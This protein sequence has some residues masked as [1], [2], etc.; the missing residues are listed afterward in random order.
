MANVSSSNGLEKR[1]KLRFPG[2]DEPWME[3]KLDS[4]LSPRVEKQIP[5]EDAPLMAFTAEGGVEPK[6][7]RYDRSYL[8]KSEDKLYKRT[9]YNDFIY[10]SNNLDVGSIGLNQKKP[11]IT[12]STHA[13]FTLIAENHLIP[14][15]GKRKIGAITE[16]DIQSYISYLY[17]SGRL[18]KS[19]GLTVKSIRDV[20]LVLR[21]AMEYAYKER[22]IPLLNWDLI[23]YPK[24]L[25]VK[26]VVSLS[27][28]QEQ[29]LIQCIYMN[30][31]RKTAGILIALFT[32]VRIGELCGLQ[33]KD[34]S[35]TDKTISINKTVQRIYDKK[36]GESY[37]HIGPPK[38]KTSAR[39]IPVPSLL[40]NIIKK[41]YTENPNHY[42]LTGKTK[43]TEPRTYRQFFS[44]FLKRHGLQKVKFHEIRHT[45]AVRAIEIPE[46]DVKSLS[47]I[48]GHKNVSFTL[49]VYGSANL[50]QKVKCMNLLNDLL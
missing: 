16:P 26:K 10:S 32:G 19:G 11:M 17:E 40:M 39:T 8:V 50:Q 48:L 22:A 27:K 1:P 9:E 3:K 44:R 46:F 29:A 36:K 23:E 42:F 33:M 41:F 7:E 20:I 12:P 38:T 24:E 34:I 45:F 14:Y 31:N 25:G 30:L 28:D 49:N 4:L 37:L 43:P 47:E 2:F 15:F 6:G 18:D 13:S 35:L 21:L 5:S